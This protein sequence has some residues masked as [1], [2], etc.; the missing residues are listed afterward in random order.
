MGSF[1]NELERGFLKLQEKERMKKTVDRIVEKIEKEYKFKVLKDF[2]KYL[3][4]LENIFIDYA[5]NRQKIEEEYI[6]SEMEIFSMRSGIDPSA[7]SVVLSKFKTELRAEK[8]RAI[9]NAIK[10]NCPNDID[11]YQEFIDHLEKVFFIFEGGKDLD[12]KT[13][14]EKILEEKIEQLSADGEPSKEELERISSDFM[15]KL[16]EEGIIKIKR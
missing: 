1:E 14:K 4:S 13:I 11:D 10:E 16:V 15:K 2:V 8:I 3:G 6:S 12:E 9:A 5:G 7:F